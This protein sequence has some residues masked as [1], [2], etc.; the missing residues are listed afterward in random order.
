MKA[1]DEKFKEVSPKTTVERIK[2]ILCDLGIR[3]GQELIAVAGEELP[4]FRVVFDDAVMHHRYPA[5]S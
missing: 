2:K 1:I 5:A 3:V 4:E